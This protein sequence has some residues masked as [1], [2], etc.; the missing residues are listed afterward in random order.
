MN[1]HIAPFLHKGKERSAV[2]RYW[3]E[4]DGE[5]ERSQCSVI[6]SVESN[7][8][9]LITEKMKTWKLTTEEWRGLIV[10]LDWDRTACHG[11]KNIKEPP[12]LYAGLDKF[13]RFMHD[14]GVRIFFVTCGDSR[15]HALRQSALKTAGVDD[16]IANVEDNIDRDTVRGRYSLQDL[17]AYNDPANSVVDEGRNY[18]YKDGFVYCNNMAQNKE[19]GKVKEIAVTELLACL[20]DPPKRV[21]VVDD[22]VVQ[23]C[24]MVEGARDYVNDK[25]VL[26]ILFGE[27]YRIGAD[28]D[29]N[30]EINKNTK[31]KNK[32]RKR[33]QDK[34]LEGYDYGIELKKEKI[35]GDE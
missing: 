9:E 23:L 21:V 22:Q 29:Q 26:G 19:G 1:S 31:A 32:K 24:S 35:D 3:N 13:V 25:N 5:W 34:E 28:L 30:T 10:L 14:K 15:W 33:E 16:C 8:W 27:K 6:S 4:T 17:T 20:P 12:E 2:S 18:L 11:I 7:N